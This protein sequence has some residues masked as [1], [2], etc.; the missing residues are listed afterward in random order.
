MNH[1]KFREFNELIGILL[2]ELHP[3]FCVAVRRFAGKGAIVSQE[4]GNSPAS[5]AVGGLAL[6]ELGNV[7]TPLATDV[8]SGH[9]N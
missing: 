5:K 3:I 2:A 1:G 9:P 4:G 8:I 7:P 6:R